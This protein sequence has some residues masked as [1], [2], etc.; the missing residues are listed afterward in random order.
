M[1]QIDMFFNS[2]LSINTTTLA[3]NAVSVRNSLGGTQIIPVLKGDAYGY[4]T[5]KVYK[6]LKDA[7]A[8]SH[9]AAAHVSEAAVLRDCGCTE[10]IMLISGVPQA[11]IRDALALN[12]TLTVPDVATAHLVAQHAE[13]PIA[14]QIKLDCGLNRFGTKLGEPLDELIRAI[15]SLPRLHVVGVY[16]H[17]SLLDTCDEATAR[18]EL[19]AYL[20][21]LAQLE[22]AGIKPILRHAAA[23]NV[24][25]WFPEAHL[26]AVRL[27]RRLFMGPP[28]SESAAETEIAE[29]AT[30]RSAVTAVRNVRSDERFGYGGAFCAGRDTTLA[31]VSVGYGDGLE[32]LLCGKTKSAP[33]MVNGRRAQLLGANMDACFIDANNCG[34][35]PGAEVVFFGTCANGAELSAR[36]VA[37]TIDEEGVY[38][39]SRLTNRVGREYIG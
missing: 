25:E 29:A 36:E 6:T 34:A 26:D 37:A 23:S 5:E 20:D 1:G 10:S 28:L 31:I 27:G 24:S 11:A 9:Y 19:N 22:A 18:R 3:N 35:A 13:K 38:L 21:G 17:F 16:T 14:V 33:V 32:P 30:W 39:T 2:T 8:P 4:G 7:I 12:V 15:K